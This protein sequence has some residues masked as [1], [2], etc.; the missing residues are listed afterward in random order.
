MDKSYILVIDD[1][2]ATLTLITALLQREYV[3]E[4]ASDGGD[5]IEKLR[6]KRYAAILLDLRMPQPDGFSVLDFL[7]EQHPALLARVLVVTAALTRPELERARAYGVCAV[8]PKPFEI[9]T[10]LAAVRECVGPADSSP[11]SGVFTNGM[12][13]LLADVLKSRF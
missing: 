8:I 1:N 11:L 12:I 7:R 2:E 6:T 10:L 5:A 13:L 4:S 9:E 3:V